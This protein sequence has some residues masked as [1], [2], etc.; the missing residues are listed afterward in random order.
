MFFIFVDFGNAVFG[1]RVISNFGS[2]AIYLN[3]VSLFNKKHHLFVKNPLIIWNIVLTLLVGFLLF[4]TSQSS[5]AGAGTST[6]D[7][8]SIVYVNTD[9]LLT[10]YDYFKD[11]QKE[12]EN[13]QYRLQTDIG[14]K[15][16]Q[17]EMEA[18]YAQ[19]RAQTM[20]QAEL[21]ATQL[22]LQKM[23][24]DF[25]AYRDGEAARFQQESGKKNEELI[26][27]I[28]AYL[29]KVNSSNKYQFVLGYTKG[30]GILFADDKYEVT[31]KIL[32][33]LNKEYAANKKPEAAKADTSK[34]GKK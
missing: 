7:G 19:Q 24:S 2:S 16:R 4:K 14:Q 26:N 22:R 20:T 17:V 25:V 27:S 13:K 23:Q 30:G 3:F 32:E 15:G 31:Q 6:A 5:S 1:Q 12:L 9:S 33:G 28:Q 18:S 11:T 10:K 8:R 29:K 21:Q 34:T